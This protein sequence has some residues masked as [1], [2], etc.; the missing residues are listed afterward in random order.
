MF[1]GRAEVI[2]GTWEDVIIIITLGDV[3]SDVWGY[4]KSLPSKGDTTYA[5]RGIK[6]FSFVKG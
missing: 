2:G 4:S 6:G 5:S 3:V 1:G